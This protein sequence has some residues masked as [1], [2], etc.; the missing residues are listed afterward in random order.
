MVDL[1]GSV[2]VGRLSRAA[3]EWVICSLVHMA[4]VTALCW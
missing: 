1:R 4:A 3:P 2:V